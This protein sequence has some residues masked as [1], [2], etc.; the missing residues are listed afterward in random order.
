MLY[1][2]GKEII[3]YYR[4]KTPII[5]YYRGKTLIWQAIRSCFGNGYWIPDYPWLSSD[6]WK[7]N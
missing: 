2:N 6:V 7:N 3:E 5:E 4:G 1:R